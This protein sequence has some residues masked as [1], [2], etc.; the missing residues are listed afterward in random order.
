MA[1]ILDR[2]G[3]V[4]QV[5]ISVDMYRRAAAA[6]MDFQTWLGR[7][8]P[9]DATKFGS[10]FAQ[11]CASEG[12]YL[13]GNR[14]MGIAAS[15]LEQILNPTPQAAVN[16]Q[17]GVP[18]S[19]ILYPPVFLQAIEDKLARDLTTT[20]AAWESMIAIDESI[21]GD[22]YEQPQI[23]Y[24]GPEAAM[25]QPIAQMAEPASML[26]ITS[27]DKA[28]KIPTLSL[29]LKISDQALRAASIDL[30]ALSVARQ[31]AIERNKRAQNYILQL[32]NGDV[33]R[34][35]ASLSAAGKVTTSNSLDSNATGGVLTQKS[36]VKYLAKNSLYRTILM[37]VTDID[38][39]M[40]IENRSGRPTNTNDNPNSP[41]I[42]T[43]LE[44]INPMW[45]NG[46]KGFL[47]LDPNWPAS[48]VMGIDTRY[49][50]RRV[51]NILADYQ[52]VEAF[53]LRRAQAMRWDFGED[54]NRLYDDAF[55]VLTIS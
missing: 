9:T 45:P 27:S 31:I 34:G 7:E 55:D 54:I 32:L 28:Y 22:R 2:N 6:N 51:R 21:T 41:R 40:A 46:V 20:P 39:A 8:Y 35:E 52:A 3:A 44:V 5:P 10:T 50:I 25:S 37:V 43:T 47:S 18:A 1:S 26:V 36:W 4:Q 19:R 23:N 33:D 17:D 42:N 30:V 12:I 11:I 24:A 29:G 13:R 53:V 38:G 48:T 15:T 49:G 16:T 14:E